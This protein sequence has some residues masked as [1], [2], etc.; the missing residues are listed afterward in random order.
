MSSP[1]PD[2]HPLRALVRGLPRPFWV[3]FAGM[4][5]NRTGTFVVPFLAIYL[6]RVRGVSVAEAG[7]VAAL[8]G[9]GAAIASPMGGFCA[10]RFGRRGTMLFALAVGGAGMI[11]MGFLRPLPAIAAAAFTVAMLGEMYRPAM[12]AAVVDLVPPGDRVRAMG[13]IYWAINLGVSFGVSLAGFLATISYRL[14]FLGDGLTTLVFAGLVW[15]GL[16]ETRR[17]ARVAAGP[18]HPLG[19]FLVAFRDPPY[20]AFLALQLVLYTIFTQHIA[21]LA[22][23]MTAHG[24]SPATF[25]VVVALNGALIVVVQPF[26]GPWLAGRDLSRVLAAGAALIACGFGLNAVARTAP[27]YALAVAVW[28]IG[29]I[30]VLPVAGAL[31]GDLAPPESRGRYQGA[32]GMMFGLAGALAPLIG[33]GVMQRFGGA[34]LWTGCLAA[35]LA[36]SLVY[37]AWGPRLTRLRRAR[38]AAAAAAHGH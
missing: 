35:G 1:A 22:L 9:A 25:G 37:L 11:A 24:L 31:I 36:V 8:W 5:V 2:R 38:V 23:D 6:T 20:V 27:M 30:G 19:E 34:A 17:P 29:E 18:A 32:H 4:L 21:A 15:R 26:V 10:D 12:Q 14:L 3:L 16:G 7:M 28:T 13:L 33:T